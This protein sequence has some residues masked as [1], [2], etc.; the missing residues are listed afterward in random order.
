MLKN[1]PLG[2]QVFDAAKVE[3]KNLSDSKDNFAST[4]ESMVLKQK[5]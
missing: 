5:N 1:P 4:K 3:L 2:K